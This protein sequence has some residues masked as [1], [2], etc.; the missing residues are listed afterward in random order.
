MRRIRRST[1]LVAFSAVVFGGT[2][3]GPISSAHAA[4]P[5]T[6]FVHDSNGAPIPGV[7]VN[8]F[9]GGLFSTVTAADGTTSWGGSSATWPT[10]PVAI[11]ADPPSGSAFGF[12]ETAVNIGPNGGTID[13]TL[14]AESTI[15]GT[16]TGPGGGPVSGVTVRLGVLY[17]APPAGSKCLNALHHGIFSTASAANGT[18]TIHN[19]GVLNCTLSF[20]PPNGSP[21]A[22]EMYSDAVS[23]AQ[24]TL[25]SV[26]G[27]GQATAGK[28]ASL[29]LAGSIAG[30]V[31]EPGGAPVTDAGLFVSTADGTVINDTSPVPT[32]N[33][34][35]FTYGGLKPGTYDIGIFSPTHDS[36]GQTTVTVVGGATVTVPDIVSAKLNLPTI[37]S[38]TPNKMGRG[39]TMKIAIDGTGFQPDAVVGATVLEAGQV[40]VIDSVRV[41]ATRMLATLTLIPNPDRPFISVDVFNPDGGGASCKDCISIVDGQVDGVVD[42]LVSAPPDR[43]LDTRPDVQ[44]GYSG[45]KPTAGQ[46]IEL[47][48]TGVGKNPVPADAG[49]V[50]LNVTGTDAASAGYVT[51]WPCGEDRPLASSLNLVPG[52]TSPNAVVTKIGAGGKVCLYTQASAH[53][54]ADVMGYFP[55]YASYIAQQPDRVL[56]TR[57]DSQTGY[58]GAKPSAGQTIELTVGGVHGVPADADAVVL[59]VTGTDAT[60]AGYVTVWPCGQ[61]QPVASSLNLVPGTTSPNAVIAQLGTDGK[62]CL[63]TQSGAHLLADVTGYF[64]AGASYTSLQPDRL[65]DTRPDTQAGY[66]GAKP[67]AGQTVELQVTGAGKDPVPTDASTVV[68]NVTGTDATGAGY[69]TVWP[70]GDAQPL[71]SS[72][73]LV[74]GVTSPNAVITKIGSGGKVCLYT[75]SGAHL[76]ADI[77]GYIA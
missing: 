67:A 55:A 17:G 73:N 64:P 48:V 46:T 68:L 2:V 24:A 39:T 14:Q 61:P 70:C 22:P 66:S 45:P 43:L 76:I 4:G 58:T 8:A 50:V 62:V 33:D 36:L 35:R 15:S 71:A 54:L 40:D 10:T 75:Q 1:A 11:A 3:L 20:V 41:S 77:T 38:I 29:E 69:V 56:D 7:T 9:V 19:L 25:I 16:V 65:L 18:Y 37:T 44:A 72:L 27:G 60:G 28:N 51:V 53:L 23:P 57:P 26:S 42:H 34:G 63:Y 6:I 12:L 52:V 32:T 13:L 31:V 74:P 49:A 59:N 5:V 47:Q 21:F 30:R